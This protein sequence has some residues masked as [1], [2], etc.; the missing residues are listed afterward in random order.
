M[1]YTVKDL[2]AIAA[3]LSDIERGFNRARRR[4]KDIDFLLDRVPINLRGNLAGYA[5][6]GADGRLT[7]QPL[8]AGVALAVAESP[9]ILEE[10]F[11]EVS[12]DE[13]AEESEVIVP[14]EES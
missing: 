5:L 10:H 12:Y 2:I 4:N 14:D 6:R 1:D 3:A 7:F 8:A 11:P 9:V 13:H